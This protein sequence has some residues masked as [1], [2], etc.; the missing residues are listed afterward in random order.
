MVLRTVTPAP[1]APAKDE[2][3]SS[4]RLEIAL[5]TTW[6][7]ES[8]GEALIAASQGFPSADLVIRS[9]SIRVRELAR[10]AMSALDDEEESVVEIRARLTGRHSTVGYVAE[11][12]HG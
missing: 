7:M 1:A 4:E 9:L 5:H 11:A 2:R 12:S 3:G 8:V 10:I 6:E